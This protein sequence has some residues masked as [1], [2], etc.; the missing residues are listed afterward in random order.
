[1]TRNFKV[2]LSFLAIFFSDFVH[3]DDPKEVK[4][5]EVSQ[6]AK[7]SAVNNSYGVV[8]NDSPSN[9]SGSNWQVQ[10]GSGNSEVSIKISPLNSFANASLTLTAP[11]DKDSEYTKFNRSERIV[12]DVSLT[13]GFS[14]IFHFKETLNRIEPAAL[15]KIVDICEADR[16]QFSGLDEKKDCEDIDA[17]VLL[18]SYEGKDLAG[19]RAVSNYHSWIG[20][21]FFISGLSIE[22]G[23]SDFKYFVPDSLEAEEQSEEAWAIGPSVSFN[24]PHRSL[25]TAKVVYQNMYKSQKAVVRCPSNSESQFVK[26][27]SYADGPPEHIERL[28]AT[29]E[30]RFSNRLPLIK[31]ISPK[32]SH[33]NSDHRW[34]F[35]LP[36]FLL[37][38]KKGIY[39]GGFNANWNSEDDEW[40]FS[41]FVGAAF[42]TF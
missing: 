17:Q 4:S 26:C 19:L 22:V 28:V 41:V 8:L 3:S 20:S 27:F 39:N 35:D 15:A 16:S 30:A 40:E 7:A 6:S 2:A 42:P 23:R 1:M 36:V 32:V 24:I 18:E 33:E 10:S 29:V 34:D 37:K 13:F 5:G 25:I 12:N 9:I 11:I 38:D 21:P 31:R 14:R